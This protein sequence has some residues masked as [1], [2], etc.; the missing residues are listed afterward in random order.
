MRKHHATFI[1]LNILVQVGL[2]GAT[3]Q[4]RAQAEKPTYPAM[5][6]VSEYLMADENSEIALARTAAPPSISDQAEVMVLGPKGFTTA[7]KGTNGFL[8]IVERSFGAATDEP[9]FGTPKFA[10]PFVSIRRPQGA[11]R[12]FS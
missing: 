5:A 4:A 2:F 3:C 8:C 10:L 6:P 11:S 9:E 12:P 1:A 7:V